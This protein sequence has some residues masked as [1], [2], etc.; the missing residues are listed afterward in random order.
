MQPALCCIGYPVSSLTVGQWYHVAAAHNGSNSTVRFY[1]DGVEV[2]NGICSGISDNDGPFIVGD[3]YLNNRRYFDGSIGDVRIFDR[4]LSASEIAAL[5][6]DSTVA[7]TNLLLHVPLTES[8]GVVAHDISTNSNDG[9]MQGFEGRE[10]TPIANSPYVTSVVQFSYDANGA[11]THKT[12]TTSEST[13]IT[14]Y[15]YDEDNRLIEVGGASSPNEPPETTHTFAYDYRSRRIFRSTPSETN[16]CVFDGGLSIQEYDATSSLTPQA[17]NLTT[18]YVRGEGMGGGVGGM[19]YSLKH[20]TTNQTPSIICSHANHRGDVIARSDMNGELTS[21]ALY[22]AYGARP[23]EWGDDPDRQKAN[24]KEEE[25]DLGLLN[26]GM[27]YRELDTGVLLTR[28]PIGYGDGPNL[29]CY[30]HCNPI[31]HFDALGLSDIFIDGTANDP[32]DGTNVHDMYEKQQ[33]VNENV[34]YFEGPKEKLDGGDT[35]SIVQSA[36]DQIAK[37]Y[38]EGDKEINIFGFSR[39]GAAANELAW[40]INDKGIVGADGTV[41]AKPGEASVNFLGMFDPVHSMGLPGGDSD[42]SWHDSIIAPNVNN[43]AIAYAKDETRNYFQ[44]SMFQ[45]SEG[46]NTTITTAWFPGYHSDV[47][48]HDRGNR[49]IGQL[50]Q[51]F[52]GAA[53]D[54]A[55][56]NVHPDYAAT[57]DNLRSSERIYQTENLSPQLQGRPKLQLPNPLYLGKAIPFNDSFKNQTFWQ[58][59]ERQK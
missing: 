7:S 12:V 52:M 36:Y 9:I 55:G 56:M 3:W 28:D 24:T 57:V 47:G 23:Y 33:E 37:N 43:A 6:S 5:A 54:H 31:T 2:G 42:P 45:R 46:A 8:F 26:E 39:G 51:M 20:N 58:H 48:G 14:E 50:T 18:E 25:S 35:M 22:E 38:A 30:V 11:R 1:I 32:N 59:S 53:A 49:Q 15:V 4:E 27:R 19:V 34:H 29:Y 10:E 17:S 41:H 40:M 16:L 13:N 21:F 44:P